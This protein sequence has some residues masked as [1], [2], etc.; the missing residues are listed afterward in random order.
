MYILIEFGTFSL[1]VANYSN[2]VTYLDGGE[3]G[4]IIW[5]LGCV[6]VSRILMTNTAAT[7]E[8]DAFY[9]IRSECQAEVPKTRF[10]IKVWKSLKAFHQL[11]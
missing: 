10:K 7:T 3:T 11:R 1:K 4:W 5:M 2:R 6:N 8:L 9:P